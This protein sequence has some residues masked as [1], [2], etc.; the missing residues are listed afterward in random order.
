MADDGMSGRTSGTD[1][2]AA[3]AAR[4]LDEEVELPGLERRVVVDR[5]CAHAEPAHLLGLEQLVPRVAARRGARRG[6]APCRCSCLL[7]C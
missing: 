6:G 4:D 3:A 1:G 7:P 2:A 5:P